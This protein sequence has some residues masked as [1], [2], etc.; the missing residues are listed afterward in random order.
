M[1]YIFKAT[2]DEAYKFKALAEV[3]HNILTDVVFIA[4]KDGIKLV[5]ID[6]KQPCRLLV[7]LSL[8]ALSFQEYHCPKQINIG[9]TLEHLYK[10]TKD[11][12]RKD[13]L[14]LFID[15]DESDMLGITVFQSD[16]DHYIPSQIKILK[17]SQ[18]EIAVP[19]GYNHPIHISTSNYQ[20]MCKR[21]QTISKT[22]IDVISKGNYIRFEC[23][24]DGV[25]NRQ[26]PFGVYDEDSQERE[27]NDT[28]NIISFSQLSKISGLNDKMQIYAPPNDNLPLKIGINVGQLGRLEIF[29]KSK[30]QL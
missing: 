10:L 30:A 11:I 8:D 16:S 21:M 28:F 18:M 27:Y 5:T 29:L 14:L 1:K 19:S 13:K 9:I 25:Y 7:N 22:T 17:H 2:T 26:E 20:K 6:D 4:N 15:K 3:L 12:K 24:I 23:Y